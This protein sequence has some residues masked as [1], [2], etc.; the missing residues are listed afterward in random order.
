MTPADDGVIQAGPCSSLVRHVANNAG[1]AVLCD[2][3][4][5]HSR[6]N[7]IGQHDLAAHIFICVI[8]FVRS[9]ADIDQFRFH[10]GAV[11]VVREMD[12]IGLPISEKNMLRT[13]FP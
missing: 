8:G 4:F 3:Q 13:H 9:V 2:R 1:S 6:Q 5:L 10:V 7:A 12:W 11:T